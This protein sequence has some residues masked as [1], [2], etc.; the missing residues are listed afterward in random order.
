MRR[1]AFAGSVGAAFVCLILGLWPA[2]SVAAAPQVVAPG[3]WLIPGGLAPDREPDGNT[4]V[5]EG[6]GGLI[7]V[8]TGRHPAQRQA[9]LDFAARRGR[10]IVAVVNS[11]WHLDHVSGNPDLKRAFPGLKVYASG[12]IDRA[13]TGFLAHSAADDRAY[14]ASS[15]LPAATREDIETD[16]ATI[17]NGQAL[18]PDVVIDHTQALRLAG[19]SLVI[20]LAPNAA[21]AGDIWL[22]DPASKVAAVG[23][24]VTLPAPF[25][26][27]ACPA[28]WSAA[29]DEI[30]ATP[31]N[32]AIPG[33]GA[34]LTRPQ[35]QLYRRAFNDLIACA[36]SGRPKGA[37]AAD[38][39]S[40]VSPLLGLAPR[41]RSLAVS[42]TEYYVGDVLRAHG[43]KSADCQDG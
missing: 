4:V 29:L 14:L 39:A 8:D 12:A 28:G 35:L 27:T 15:G 32:V 19:R 2:L 21:T 3:I 34:P 5:L 23:D 37:C 36:G 17:A 6:R 18:R 40:A 41:D 16:L 25:L 9:I 24:L 42:L 11:H 31:F 26:D 1:P 22:F 10:P 38:W 43:G 33:H 20:H 30:A 13:L 7:V